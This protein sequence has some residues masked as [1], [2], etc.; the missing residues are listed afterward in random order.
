MNTRLRTWVIGLA[1][2]TG[3]SITASLGFWQL[4]RAAQ[5]QA[6]QAAV[7]SQALADPLRNSDLLAADKPVHR[8]AVLRGR[9]IP[10]HTVFLD[11]RQMGGRVGFYVLTPLALEG[12]SAVLL[13]QRGW[14]PRNFTQR[15]VLPPIETPSA[16]VE[17]AGRMAPL[18]GKLYD[19]GGPESGAIRQNMDLEAFRA[20]T[21]LALLGFTLQQTGPASE[22]MMR[23]WP[24]AISGVDKHYGY[25]FQWFGIGVAMVIFFGWVQFVRPAL[26]RSK[27]LQSHDQ[28]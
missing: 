5:K 6:I 11:N 18:P 10:A 8:R 20:E 23:E 22:G 21:G 17:V 27:K 7:D 3:V 26:Q 12:S 14:V 4:N 13:V 25:A 2:L 24:A 9:W 19:L 1:T 28:P 15:E 16:V